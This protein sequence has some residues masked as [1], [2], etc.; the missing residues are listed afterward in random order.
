MRL[1]LDFGRTAHETAHEEGLG[2]RA[3]RARVS[4]LHSSLALWTTGASRSSTAA[5][6]TRPPTCQDA[7]L[8]RRPAHQL[9]ATCGRSSSG[10]VG[11]T[12]CSAQP[13]GYTGTTR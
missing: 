7:H 2:G 6:Q 1:R 8:L 12:S 5:R 13:L 9:R 10:A 11:V 3:C 4:R